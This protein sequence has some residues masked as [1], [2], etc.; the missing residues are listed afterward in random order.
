MP[1]NASGA[2]VPRILGIP[3]RAFAHQNGE[4]FLWSPVCFGAGVGL[5]FMAPAEPEIT[6]LVGLFATAVV[7]AFSLRLWRSEPP[8]LLAALVGAVLLIIS[9]ANVASWRAHSLAEPVLKFRYY[10]PVEGRVVAIDRSASEKPRYMLDH[11]RLSRMS[12]DKTPARVRISSHGPVL[13]TAIRP[14][15]T[16]IT[17]GHLGPPPGPVEPGSFDFQRHVW[18]KQLGALG[19][20]RNPILRAAAAEDGPQGPWLRLQQLRY[21]LSNTI[22]TGIGGLEGPFAAAIITGDR[23]DLDPEALSHLRRANLAHLLAISGLHMGLLTGAVFWIVRFALAIAAPV[24]LRM[25]ARKIAAVAA[26]VAAFMYLGISG[27]S[28]AT[29]RAFIMVCVMLLAICL[30]R[31]ALSLRAVA[32][33]GLI[34]LFLTP[35]ALFGPGFQ[36][37][38]AATLALV[39]AFGAVR[40]TGL[41]TALP[42]SVTW[43][44][45]LVISSAVAGAATAPY[46]A[47]HFNQIAQ[48]GLLANLLSVPVMGAVV[49]PGALLAAA[50]A[51]FGLEFVGFEIMRLGLAWILAVADF[52]SAMEGSTRAVTSPGPWVLPMLTLGGLVICLW[53]GAG[54]WAGTALIAASFVIWSG[55]ERPQLLISES[56]R[57]VGLHGPE[58]RSLNKPTGEGFSARVWL[59]NDGD[60]VSQETAAGRGRMTPNQFSLTLG[61]QTLSY[62]ARA[63]GKLDF[64]ALCTADFV[65]VPRWEERLPVNCEGL[66]A[67]DFQRDGAMAVGPTDLGLQI[68][69]SRA[70]QGTRLW[71]IAAQQSN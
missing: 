5:Y 54:R 39:A 28:I 57:L 37:S 49:M 19:Y 42:S 59:E 13:V 26:F 27:A 8:P 47:A 58:G 69:T 38:F 46:A 29:Q 51:P 44:L 65:V 24:N 55:E 9:G 50:L 12:P 21:G 40:D 22:K 62:D 41:F 67:L 35:E 56:G 11:V 18:F 10:G 4:R 33:A 16:I 17:T 53:K 15:D 68:D 32:L 71:G 45:S 36:M 52:V 66:S 3:A 34:V 61:T 43:V 6:M 60:P 2:R 70:H 25:D 31:P 23:A 64:T 14:G 20:T 63:P 48:F 1:D 7:A 30:E